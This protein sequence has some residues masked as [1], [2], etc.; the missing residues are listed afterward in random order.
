MA[1]SNKYRGG[2]KGIQVFAEEDFAKFFDLA[3]IVRNRAASL[4]EPNFREQ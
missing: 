2:F 4:G 1:A 3:K